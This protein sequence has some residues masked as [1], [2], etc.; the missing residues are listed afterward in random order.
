LSESQ[1][2]SIPYRT[3][4]EGDTPRPYLYLLVTGI[5]GQ[6]GPIPGI[7]DS[8]ADS[9]SLPFA[10]ADL[11]GYDDSTLVEEIFGQA[12]GTGIGYK[13]IKPSIAFVPEIPDSSF[14]FFPQFIRNSD[15]ALWGRMDFMMHFEVTIQEFNQ[16]F[17]ILP[18]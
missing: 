9:T 12:E 15:T 8:G 3:F 5:N 6:S 10:Y 7:V 1:P 16:V 18:I 13:A 11:M 17:T 2:F 4:V 14:E